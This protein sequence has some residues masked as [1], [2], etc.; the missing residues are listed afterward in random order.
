MSHFTVYKT[1]LGNLTKQNLIDAVRFFAA[2]SGM[3]AITSTDSYQGRQSFDIGLR[4]EAMPNGIGFSVDHSGNLCVHGDP[5]NQ[6]EEYQRIRDMATNGL[7]T[8]S[9]AV[10]LNA[11][12][13]NM[14]VK[15]QV[16]EKEIIMVAEY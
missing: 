14:T 7:I 12:N 1:A 8:N 15:V 4:N 9:Y 5:Y 3:E 13:N 6:E 10:A 16:K 2:Q 11:R